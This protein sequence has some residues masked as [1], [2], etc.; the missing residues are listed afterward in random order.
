MA[1]EERGESSREALGDRDDRRAAVA[2]RTDADDAYMHELAGV[3]DRKIKHLKSSSRGVASDSAALL[4]ALQ[5]ADE[6][7][8]ERRERQELR[9]QVRDKSRS[10]LDYIRREAKL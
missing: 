9:R 10:I 4:A 8:R 1:P 7:H 3:V 5:L 6:L 2:I